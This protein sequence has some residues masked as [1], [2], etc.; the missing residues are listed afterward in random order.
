MRPSFIGAAGQGDLRNLPSSEEFPEC[1]FVYHITE[2][3]F[4][5]MK[6]VGYRGHGMMSPNISGSCFSTKKISR[7]LVASI[8]DR[9]T[10]GTFN[11]GAV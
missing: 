9:A 6:E 2:L 8:M 4:V 11:W 10:V 5:R 1:T 7:V 3:T